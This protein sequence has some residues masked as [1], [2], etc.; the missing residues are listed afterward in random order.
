MA[1]EAVRV[2][3]PSRVLLQNADNEAFKEYE[4]TSIT[5]AAVKAALFEFQKVRKMK[6]T[7]PWITKMI[8]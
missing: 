6:K 4:N 2:R 3:P 1:V 5:K 8:S 7:P